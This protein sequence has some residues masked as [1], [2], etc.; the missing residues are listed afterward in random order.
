MGVF[1]FFFFNLDTFRLI[2]LLKIQLKSQLLVIVR[3]VLDGHVL[4]RRPSQPGVFCTFNSAFCFPGWC[5]PGFR[6]VA[7]RGRDL[8]CLVP[9]RCS[10]GRGHV[11]VS[12]SRSCLVTHTC[13]SQQSRFR[14]AA[15]IFL[16]SLDPLLWGLESRVQ[17]ASLDWVLKWP[18]QFPGIWDGTENPKDFF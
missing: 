17:T 12:P 11:A 10:Q 4:C 2:T 15:S 6:W 3:H 13:A 18:E 7:S 16:G 8:A 9:P 1:F 5:S 14:T